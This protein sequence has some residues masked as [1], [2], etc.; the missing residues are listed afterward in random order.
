MACMM[1]LLLISLV[2]EGAPS[3]MSPKK[4][5]HKTAEESDP[6]SYR[7]ILDPQFKPSSSLIHPVNNDSISPWTY[8][9]TQDENLYPSSIAEAKCLLTGCLNMGNE[10]DN[11]Y[12]SKPIYRQI[13]V[14]RRI[15]GD[16][17][18]YYFRL[19]NKSIAVGCTCVRPY[20]EEV[21]T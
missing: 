18:N 3:K 19:E 17:H 16:K 20:T 15:R 1:G 13:L 5:N 7:L 14:L 21:R 10:E 8:T 6:P 12:A 11:N 4:G 2:V 9:F